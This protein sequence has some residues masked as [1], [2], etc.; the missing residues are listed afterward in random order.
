MIG[1]LFLTDFH[2]FAAAAAV[3]VAVSFRLMRLMQMC[4][5]HSSFHLH[6]RQVGGDT[7]RHI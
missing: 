6:S 7:A 3:A 4:K 2:L 5:S 1:A